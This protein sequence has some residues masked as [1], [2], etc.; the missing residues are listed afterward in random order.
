M[1][2]LNAVL[3]GWLRRL[4]PTRPLGR[5]GEKAA[6]RY[7]RRLGYRI[8]SHSDRSGPGEIDLVAVDGRTVVFVEVKTRQSGDAGHPSEAVDDAK[9]RRLTRLALA[10]LKRHGLLEQPAR[11]DIVAV[12]WPEDRRRPVIEH[13]PNAFEAVGQRGFHS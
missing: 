5:R 4:F 10:Y 9:Q 12:T 7:L 3:S 11:F 6:A 8:V 1:R 2:R 13:F